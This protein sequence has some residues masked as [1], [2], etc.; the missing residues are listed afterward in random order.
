[1]S[2]KLSKNPDDAA[3]GGGVLTTPC[4]WVLREGHS[5]VVL[6]WGTG[7]DLGMSQNEGGGG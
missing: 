7:E 1:M 4:T 5:E 2:G 3:R 6:G